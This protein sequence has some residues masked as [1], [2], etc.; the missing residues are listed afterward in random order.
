MRTHVD[1]ELPNGDD[2]HRVAK[3]AQRNH[4]DGQSGAF[5]TG[6]EKK[7]TGDQTGNEE[8]Q[9][10]MN[11]AALGSDLE[12][13]PRELKVQ[14]VAQKRHARYGKKGIRGL[15]GCVLKKGFDPIEQETRKGNEKDEKTNG[16]NQSTQSVAA[17]GQAAGCGEKEHE[18]KHH[19]SQVIM[20]YRRGTRRVAKPT[21][22]QH[23]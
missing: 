7:V 12:L 3:D 17:Q 5:P 15:G 1:A 18:G 11:A 6:G 2:A 8:H 23:A 20:P 14:T 10:G 16:E 21:G 9:A 19:P 22:N 13:N 4:G